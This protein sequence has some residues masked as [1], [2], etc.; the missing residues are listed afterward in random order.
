MY[1]KLGW[2]DIRLHPGRA[3]LTLASVVIAVAGVVAVTF[4]S[5]TTRRAFDE[6]Y[7]TIAGRAALE[8][9]APIGDTFDESLLDTVARVPGVKAAAPFIQRI[10]ILYIGRK[11]TQLTA[12]GIDPVRR[13]R[14]ARL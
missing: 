8:I 9:S 3:L 11:G 2:R 1:A 13:P 14:S 12:M 10:I 4:A 5:Q 7:Q 6:I